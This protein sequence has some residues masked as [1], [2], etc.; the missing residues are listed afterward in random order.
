MRACSPAAVEWNVFV[1]QRKLQ[2]KG[3]YVYTL[4]FPLLPLPENPMVLYPTGTRKHL[5][6]LLSAFGV[7]TKYQS[8]K[9][10][11]PLNADYNSVQLEDQSKS[12]THHVVDTVLT[13]LDSLIP[14][15]PS[16]HRRLENFSGRNSLVN[17]LRFTLT[18]FV[19][20]RAS[21]TNA[22]A[23]PFA[24]GDTAR[25]YCQIF[26]RELDSLIIL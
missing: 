10:V 11:L 2:R 26:R 16:M 18:L 25:Q 1:R 17:T 23:Q 22:I 13:N 8:S 3:V 14:D 4:T 15:K 12:Y 6:Q 5:M 19:P 20:G 7:E 9:K 21:L 24:T